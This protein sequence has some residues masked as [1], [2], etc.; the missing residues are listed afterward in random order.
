MTLKFRSIPACGVVIAWFFVLAMSHAEVLTPLASSPDWKSLEPY[1]Y[2]ITKAEFTRL[3]DRFFSPNGG[4]WKFALTDGESVT[5]YSD[6]L[7]ATPLFMLYF[8]TDDDSKRPLPTLSKPKNAT[9]E[10]G[11]STPSATESSLE[12]KVSLPLSGCRICLDPGHIGGE[13]AK[14]EERYFKIAEYPAVEEAA[15]NLTVCRLLAEKLQ[16]A[17]AEVVWTKQDFQPVATCKVDD[18][19]NEAIKSLFLESGKRFAHLSAPELNRRLQQREELLFYRV[20]EIRAR[21]ERVAALHPDLT[22]CVHFNAASWGEPEHPR[23]VAENRL[24][25]FIAGA[26]S[27]NEL[28]YDDQKFDML[29]KLLEQKTG[30]ALTTAESI[31]HEMHVTWPETPHETYSGWNAVAKEGETGFTFARN[32]LANRLYPGTVVFIEG[33]YMNNRDIY[34]RMIAG[35]YEGVKTVNG[36][37]QTSIFREFADAIARGVIRNAEQK[38][39]AI[40]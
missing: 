20:A 39:K 13:Y 16:A 17:G 32:L 22:L 10:E 21:S 35:D 38:K 18:L 9:A 27:E 7:R 12:E 30:A 19:R 4:F 8:A 37:E 1:Q 23:L 6:H 34:P 40:Q 14:L 15:L 24:V 36:K 25:L 26:F 2:T 5:I 33:P 11:S 31:A 29:H 3:V 28:A